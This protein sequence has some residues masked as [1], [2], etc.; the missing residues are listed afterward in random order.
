[1]LET[2]GN[3]LSGIAVYIAVL[4]A[5][6]AAY[7]VWIAFREWLTSRRAAFGIERDIATS[8]MVGAVVRAGGI[9]MLGLLVLAVGRLGEGVGTLGGGPAGAASGS[10]TTTPAPTP[11]SD[12]T[13]APGVTA[14]APQLPT[15][16][17]QPELG[18]V[19]PLPGDATATLEP[20]LA[21]TPQTARVVAV[22]G[23]W[24][25][26]APNG[27]TIVV[28]PQETVVEFQEGRENVGDMT[29]QRVRVASIPPGS[30]NVPGL[31][32]NIEGWVAAQFLEAT[33]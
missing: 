29:W 7:F 9:V 14:A 23:V 30:P 5:L 17:T 24:L 18:D 31:E 6:V 15:D 33:Q 1:M 21:P 3:I 25:R 22:G 8:E 4:L 13:P 11:G 28:L 19:P 2:L 10:A 27:G 20:A 32:V 12:E 26:D 16:T